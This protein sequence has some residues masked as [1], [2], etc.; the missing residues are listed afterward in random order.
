MGEQNKSPTSLT[1]VIALDFDGVVSDMLSFCTL[2]RDSKDT[3][4]SEIVENIKLAIQKASA[5]N[6]GE[7]PLSYRVYGSLKQGEN[8]YAFRCTD[9]QKN[10]L[11]QANN[12]NFFETL[13]QNLFPYLDKNLQYISDKKRPLSD[14]IIFINNISLLKTYLE[15]FSNQRILCVP[16]SNRLSQVVAD[17]EEGGNRY[18][19]E[20][21]LLAL[22]QGF[23]PNRNFL[24]GEQCRKITETSNPNETQPLLRLAFIADNREDDKVVLLKTIRKIYN[25]RE[26]EAEKFFFFDDNFGH[27][28]AAN[29]ATT[30]K[31]ESLCS[32]RLALASSLQSQH[33][34]IEHLKKIVLQPLE[35]ER[36]VLANTVGVKKQGLDNNMFMPLACDEQTATAIYVLNLI[37]TLKATA[38]FLLDQ[39]GITTGTDH[40]IQ[41]AIEICQKATTWFNSQ[42]PD[43]T[44]TTALIT[45]IDKVLA[46]EKQKDIN[47]T[48]VATATALNSVHAVF[49]LI[50]WL[51]QHAKTVG[52]DSNEK[53]AA[54]ITLAQTLRTTANTFFSKP[55][56]EKSSVDLSKFLTEAQKNINQ[57]LQK[58]DSPLH[59]HRNFWGRLWSMFVRKVLRIQNSTLGASKTEKHLRQVQGKLSIF[60]VVPKPSP[61]SAPIPT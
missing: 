10:A 41:S 18:N 39:V 30:E 4:L 53:K 31:N 19:M 26:L 48:I 15:Y 33:R 42:A 29:E 43:N 35:D 16:A 28:K 14:P 59:Q 7:S 32:A 52:A 57:E 61:N 56:Q 60:A 50:N 20:L 38:I 27:I 9:A 21:M 37:D 24:T 22:D 36:E 58:K 51:E 13:R 46:G 3:Q 23:G 44:E 49:E 25:L 55:T 1:A 45:S 34:L 47:T 40:L 11:L 2:L 12:E 5:E 8:V 54:I 17:P 6:T